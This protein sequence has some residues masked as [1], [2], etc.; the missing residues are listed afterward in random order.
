[1]QNRG[2]RRQDCG[3]SKN[4]GLYADLVPDAF[5]SDALAEALKQKLAP[6]DKTDPEGSPQDA[7]T[8]DSP[9]DVPPQGSPQ[10][11]PPQDRQI[12]PGG[13][14]LQDGRTPFNKVWYLKAG[15]ADSHLKQA[16]EEVCRFEEI[17]VYENRA[18]EPK[19]K[20]I[21]H[22][23]GYA[24]ILF[25]CASSAERL[26]GALGTEWGKCRA[27]SIGPKTTARL[28]ALGI[29]HVEEA[30]ENSYEGLVKMLSQPGTFSP[31]T[32][33]NKK[34]DLPEKI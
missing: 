26:I 34:P 17:V 8:Q 12:S 20:D 14:Y 29:E 18:V 11:A 32:I 25:T 2:Y 33:K 24:G 13:E 31:Y 1:M 4:Q 28:K 21:L 6:S 3:G 15:N 16:L 19:T 30:G 7:P 23:P 5:H 9:Q 27:Y 22:L 10:D